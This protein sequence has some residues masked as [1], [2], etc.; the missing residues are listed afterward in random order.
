MAIDVDSAEFENAVYWHPTM[1]LR[2]YRPAGRDDN[3][4]RLEQL[5]ERITGERSWRPVQT[6]LEPDMPKGPAG[7]SGQVGWLG[8][9]SDR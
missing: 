2:W 8:G 7:D 6:I 9:E 4:I 1:Q 3:D 5:W